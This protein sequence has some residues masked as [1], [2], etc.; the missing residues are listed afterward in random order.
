MG[1]FLAERA[2]QTHVIQKVDAGLR[3]NV[4]D[5]MSDGKIQLIINTPTRTGWKTDEG[6]IRAAA[7][8]LGIAMITTITG[9]VAA[10]KSIRALREHDWGVGAMQD[11]RARAGA[12]P[13][14]STA[15]TTAAPT[16]S[17]A[18]TPTGAAT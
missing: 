14:A 5:L 11:Y 1:A 7:V 4:V 12:T 3:P 2:V 8:R 15:P 17:P 13:T 9:A 6:K 18:Q 16:G 10:V